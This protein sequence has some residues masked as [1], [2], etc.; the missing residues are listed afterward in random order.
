MLT[1][2]NFN[3]SWMVAK[4]GEVVH[5]ENGLNTGAFKHLFQHL[6]DYSVIFSETIYDGLCT[7]ISKFRYFYIYKRICVSIV[8]V[9]V[10]LYN[11]QTL[12]NILWQ[13]SEHI[14]N[15]REDFGV[16]KSINKKSLMVSIPW[17]LSSYYLTR[18]YCL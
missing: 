9:L 6:L 15:Y 14:Y 11:F 2:D 7:K 18:I 12:I 10:C 3:K 1:V 8:T 4:I 5:Y 17:T 16:C 13:P